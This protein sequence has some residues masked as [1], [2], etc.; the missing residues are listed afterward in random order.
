MEATLTPARAPRQLKVITLILGIAAPI[1]V[2]TSIVVRVLGNLI[3]TIVRL[4]RYMLFFFK[5]F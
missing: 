5:L 3:G 4:D 1:V 2:S